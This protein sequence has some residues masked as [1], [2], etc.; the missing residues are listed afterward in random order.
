MLHFYRPQRSCGQGYVFTRVCDSVHRGG[1]SRQGEPPGWETTT[2]TPHPPRDQAPPRTRQTTPPGWETNP[3]RDQAEPP[4]AGRPPPPGPGRPPPAGRPPPREADFRI[5]STSGGTHPTGMHSC[6]FSFDCRYRQ[7]KVSYWEKRHLKTN[8]FCN[9]RWS[10]QKLLAAAEMI[11]RITHQRSLTIL[12]RSKFDNL[13]D[14]WTADV[15]WN[16]PKRKSLLHYCNCDNSTS[17]IILR[18]HAVSEKCLASFATTEHAVVV[19]KERSLRL[20]SFATE[21]RPYYYP[22]GDVS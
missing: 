3:P 12:Q 20:A 1:F 6:K 2:P 15:F 9:N 8:V 14:Y 10:W 17:S 18:H 13:S 7:S 19:N 21:D 16:N 4:P 5:R 22:T 11:S